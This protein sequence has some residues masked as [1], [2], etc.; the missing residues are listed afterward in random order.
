MFQLIV[1]SVLLL[2]NALLLLC[3]AVMLLLAY[4]YRHGVRF[5]HVFVALLLLALLGYNSASP[6]PTPP[7][8]STA[9]PLPLRPS[10]HPAQT[11][12]SCS[13][14]FRVACSGT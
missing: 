11:R 8:H 13:K 10:S 7:L 3:A 12:C 1:R 4:R 14:S 2:M 5:E 6:S 9:P